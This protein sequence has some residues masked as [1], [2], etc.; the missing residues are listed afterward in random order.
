ASTAAPLQVIADKNA[1]FSRVEYKEVTP[2]KAVPANFDD[3][4]VK[5]AGEDSAANLAEN[6]E[7]IV[8]GRHYTVMLFPDK[9]ADKKVAINVISDDLQVPSAGKAR[10]RVINAAAGTDDIE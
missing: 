7:S 5:T 10:V 9:D 8:S 6:S 2:Y 1:I 4:A 3:F